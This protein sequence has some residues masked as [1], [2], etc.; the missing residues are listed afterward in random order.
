MREKITTRVATP[1]DAAVLARMN[2]TF[3]GVVEPPAVLAD[4]LAD[5][6]CV[7]TPLL[8]E[9]DG[10]VVGL[11]AL[12][13]VPCV[14]YETPHAELT[15]LYVEPAFRRGGV[16]QVLIAQA[17]QLARERGARMLLVLTD[18]YNGPA[19][20]LYHRTGFVNHDL[21]LQKELE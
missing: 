20:A 18:F 15:E 16:G 1:A 6:D 9:I 14:F 2:E 5:P 11:A 17:E 13:V 21:A 12:R 8:A 10:Q 3:N 19:L 7:E 4:R